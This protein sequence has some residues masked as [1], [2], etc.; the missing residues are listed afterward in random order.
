MN[1]KD[2][3]IIKK[4]WETLTDELRW[5]FLANNSHLNLIVNLDNDDTFVTHPNIEDESLEFNE[6]IGCKDG[7]PILLKAFNIKAEEV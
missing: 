7:I 4:N 1:K 5:K 3:E 2:W 6:F